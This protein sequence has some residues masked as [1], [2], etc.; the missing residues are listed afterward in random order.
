MRG[1]QGTNVCTARHL[2]IGNVERGFLE[3]DEVFEDEFYIH[4]VAHSPMET[5]AA[6]AQYSPP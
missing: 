4:P 5:H 2:T 6:V 3:A 1:S